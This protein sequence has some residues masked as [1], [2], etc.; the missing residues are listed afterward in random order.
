[1]KPNKKTPLEDIVAAIW[2]RK[3][4]PKDFMDEFNRRFE[5]AFNSPFC[6][7]FFEQVA[8]IGGELNAKLGLDER[9]RPLK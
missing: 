8:K 3:N 9:G 6:S 4:P 2:G 7:D 1:M 5:E